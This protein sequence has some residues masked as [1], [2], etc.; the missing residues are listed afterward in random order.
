[1]IGRRSFAV[2]ALILATSCKK[3]ERCKNCGMKI[4][5]ASP[6]NAELVAADGNVRF[7]TPRCAFTYWRG[8]K[9]TA[10]DIRAQDYYD[11]KWRAGAELKFVLGSDVLGP[12]GP[13]L[14]P[15]DLARAGKFIQ[16]HAADR[17]VTAAE[18]T[19]EVLNGIK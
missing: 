18:V 7:D 11:R 6:W 15:V 16:D 4:D 2:G 5:P 10:T 17:A 12:M 1:M 9:L 14:V 3:E 19:T 13:D 8:G